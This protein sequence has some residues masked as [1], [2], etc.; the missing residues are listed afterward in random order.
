MTL[1]EALATGRPF[2]RAVNTNWIIN[3]PQ[4]R[5]YLLVED[6]TAEDWEIQEKRI[7]ITL[8]EFSEAYKRAYEAHNRCGRLMFGHQY[9][10]S[11]DE[12]AKA[13]GF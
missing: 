3:N 12:I 10:P 13:M 7:R 5:M 9:A 11:V 8:Q 1:Y 2:K 4:E 6:L